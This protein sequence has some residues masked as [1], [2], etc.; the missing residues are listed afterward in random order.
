MIETYTILQ[1][2]VA[3]AEWWEKGAES[4]DFNLEL[5]AF[6]TILTKQ[7][8]YFA[9]GTEVMDKEKP[10]G[11]SICTCLNVKICEIVV[12]A[13]NILEEKRLKAKKEANGS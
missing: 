5:E 3:W 13:M 12:Q 4:N 10:R 8:R 11:G 9:Y 2:K 7:D 6:L 1:I